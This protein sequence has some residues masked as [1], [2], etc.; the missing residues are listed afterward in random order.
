VALTGCYASTEPA[1]EVKQSSARLHAQ[2]TADNGEASSYFEYRPTGTTRVATSAPFRWPAGVSGPFSAT[3]AGLTPSTQYSFR[4][5]GRDLSGGDNACAQTRTFTTAPAT[6]DEVWGG[7]FAGP[8]FNGTVRATSGPSG[9]QA[10]GSV[11]TSSFTGFVTCLAVD[12][13]R[14]AVGAVGEGALLLTVID[15][16]AA[17]GDSARVVTSPAAVRPDCASA[18][19]DNLTPIGPEEG[20]LVVIDAP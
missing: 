13:N 1:T 6:R 12:G 4:V 16:R 20:D 19:F 5:C 9:E 11:S 7:W 2:G 18:S 10:T 3:A 14:A 15:G 8:V 17:G